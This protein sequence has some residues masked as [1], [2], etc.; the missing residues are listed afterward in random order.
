MAVTAITPFQLVA[1]TMSDDLNDSDGTVASVVGDGWAIALGTRGSTDR[2]LLRVL[3]DG[4][5]DTIVVAAGDSQA[6]LRAKGSKSYVLAA[7]D[8]RIIVL[9]SGRHEQDDGTILIT[10]SDTGTKMAAFLMPV[11]QGGGGAIA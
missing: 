1:G 8:C 2:L 10:C 9:E 6:P 5:G 7:S 11:A 3:A 4:T